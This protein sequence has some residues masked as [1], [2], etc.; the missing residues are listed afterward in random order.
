MIILGR[1]LC[2]R[3]EEMDSR[4]LRLSKVYK[5]HSPCGNRFLYKMDR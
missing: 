5:F 4:L 3:L 1:G 2:N